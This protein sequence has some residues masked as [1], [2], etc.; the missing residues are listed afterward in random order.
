MRSATGDEIIVSRQRLTQ[1]AEDNL[2]RIKGCYM[3]CFSTVVALGGG[4]GGC[5]G[6]MVGGEKTSLVRHLSDNVLT[7][8]WMYLPLIQSYQRYSTL[9]SKGNVTLGDL[10]TK[11]WFR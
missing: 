10:L 3:D 4:G 11:Y 8:D 5:A 6:G 9:E 2:T 1:L 7:E